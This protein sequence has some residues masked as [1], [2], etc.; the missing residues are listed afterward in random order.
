MNRT[1]LGFPWTERLPA[2]FQRKKGYDLLDVLPVMINVQ[3]CDSKN[4]EH[5]WTT[6]LTF[7]GYGRGKLYGV[8]ALVKTT[9]WNYRAMRTRIIILTHCLP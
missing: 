1:D 3:N 8:L 6:I 2:E 5:I 9:A 4:L 7:D